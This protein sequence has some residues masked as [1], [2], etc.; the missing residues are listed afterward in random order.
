M[1]KRKTY[2]A[3]ADNSE[4]KGQKNVP[5]E[6]EEENTDMLQMLKESIEENQTRRI[7]EIMDGC[8]SIQEARNKIH[9]LLKPMPEYRRAERSYR[10]QDEEAGSDAPKIKTM[11]VPEAAQRYSLGLE[12]TKRLAEEAE[13]VIRIGKCYLIN[14]TKVDAYLDS[15]SGE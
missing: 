8:Y 5:E 13:A 15:M 12:T 7:L 9:R 14:I 11:R 10:R 6:P 1:N 4:P 2:Q 3:E